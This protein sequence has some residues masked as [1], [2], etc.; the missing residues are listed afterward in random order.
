MDGFHHRHPFLEDPGRS[1][2]ILING[3]QTVFLTGNPF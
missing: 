1:Q 3:E 2:G